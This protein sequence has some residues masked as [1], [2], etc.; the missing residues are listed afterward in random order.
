MEI[1]EQ[2]IQ[3]KK[4]NQE[5]CEDGLFV[6][7][8][9]IAVV[10][11]ATSSSGVKLPTKTPGR[12]A[13]ELVVG[14]MNHL[15]PSAEAEAALLSLNQ[16]IADSYAEAGVYKSMKSSPVDR[17]SASAVVYS[18]AR[19]ELWFIGDCQA[20]VDGVLV[21]NTKLVD[22]VTAGARALFLEACLKS[23]QSLEGLQRHDVG[24]EYIFPLLQRQSYFQNGTSP[25]EFN[26]AALDGFFS[27]TN[28]IKIVPVPKSAHEIALASDG[29]PELL[30]TLAESEKALQAVLTEDPLLFRKYKSAKGLQP[31]NNSFD[32]RTYVRV[33]I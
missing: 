8:H 5:E 26:F 31:G 12:L 13:M 16:K 20:L 11:G 2:F 7:E 28:L 18:I 17:W 4:L 27:D 24:R 32:D 23:G 22:D 10:D 9:Y 14:A 25:S 30:P 1:L 19:H 33:K 29:Y 21:T 15:E 6:G 3:G